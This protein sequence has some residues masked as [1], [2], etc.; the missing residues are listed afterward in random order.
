MSRIRNAALVLTAASLALGVTRTA[1]GQTAAPAPEAIRVE[2]LNEAQFKALP[3][4]RVIEFKGLKMTKAAFITQLRERSAA[5][6]ADFSAKREE[7]KRQ[8]EA[9]HAAV[10]REQKAKLNADNA[11]VMRDA[12]RLLQASGPRLTPQ[13]IEE[14]KQQVQGLVDRLGSATSTEERTQIDQGA[15]ELHRRLD[16]AV[17][18]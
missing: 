9:R 16:G 4:D 17:G 12:A 8:F 7:I 6:Q 18:R 14:I 1:H 13:Q 15:E 3:D 10:E 11:Q 5:A 2:Q